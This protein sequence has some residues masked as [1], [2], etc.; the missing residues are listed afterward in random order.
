MCPTRARTLRPPPAYPLAA[1]GTRGR[2]ALPLA[3][4]TSPLSPWTPFPPLLPSRAHHRAELAAI[5]AVPMTTATPSPLRRAPE[6]LHLVANPLTEPRD[7]KGPEQPP[8]SSSPSFGPGAV[9]RRIRPLRRAPEL[10]D[11]P[12]TIHVSSTP[13]PLL[14]FVRSRAVAPRPHSRAPPS[15]MDAGHGTDVLLRPVRRA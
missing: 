15:A 9:L 8:S 2:H 10:A 3:P 13:F 6:L 4:C 1:G 11:P 5:V 14:L 7:R 12:C